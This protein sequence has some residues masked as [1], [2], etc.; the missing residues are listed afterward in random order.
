MICILHIDT[1]TSNCSVALSR[2]GKLLHIIE[3]NQ[4]NIH[5]SSLTLFIEKLL[6]ES[7]VSFSQLD[8]IAVGKGPGSYTG[9]RIGVST[10][11]GLAYALNIPLISIN[12]LAI[13]A[14]GIKNSLSETEDFLLCPMIDARRMEVYCA[15]FDK[16]LCVVKETA[17]E[18]IDEQ[19]FSEELDQSVVYFFG[20]GASKCKAVLGTHPNARFIDHIFPSAA[21]MTDEAFRLYQEKQ[22]EDTAYFEPFYLKEFLFKK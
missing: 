1:S 3:E 10:A 2:D 20:D 17:A 4:Q 8:A 5:A 11:K 18:I 12:T 15:F 19:S 21:Y 6:A 7:K 22:F 9:L 13:M 16:Q 14:S